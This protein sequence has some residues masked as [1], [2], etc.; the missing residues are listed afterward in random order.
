M[1]G[2]GELKV[3]AREGSESSPPGQGKC[4]SMAGYDMVGKTMVAEDVVA[5][6]ASKVLGN[7][8]KG[9]LKIVGVGVYVRAARRSVWQKAGQANVGELGNK[10]I[11]R[12]KASVLVVRS[13]PARAEG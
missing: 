10:M 12:V 5:E 2:D 1:E 6:L 11:V 3:S 8:G 9:E 7:N 13:G 4:S